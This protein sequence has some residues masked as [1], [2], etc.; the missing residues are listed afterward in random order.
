MKTIRAIPLRLQGEAIPARIE[1]RGE[2]FMPQ[3]GF[4]AMNEE[5]RRRGAK[6]FANP[7]N[8]AA[9]SL[10]QLDPRITAQRPLTF[11]CYGSGQLEGA[12]C[13]TVT[14]SACSAL[15]P[16]DCRSANG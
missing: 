14:I 12:R 11:Y 15:S 10:R 3:D 5:A 9:G 16:G 13:R 1:V 7:R 8:A 4:E 2:V 6:I